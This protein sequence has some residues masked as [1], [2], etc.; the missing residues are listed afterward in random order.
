MILVWGWKYGG[1]KEDWDEWSLNSSKY[2]NDKVVRIDVRNTPSGKALL[3]QCLKQYLQQADVYLF[4]HRNHGYTDAAIQSIL[5]DLKAFI[6]KPGTKLRCF[7]FGEGNDYIYLLKQSRGL[8]GTKGT[9]TARIHLG[10]NGNGSSTLVSAIHDEEKKVLK[11][12]NF[13]AIWHYYTNTFKAKIFELKEDLFTS[14]LSFINVQNLDAL[15]LYQFMK[16][17]HNQLIFLRLLSFSGKMRKRS[18]LEG[19]LKEYE[20]R[21]KKSYLFDDCKANLRLIYGEKESQLYQE[22][23][24]QISNNLLVP[25]GNAD[26]PGLRDQ[27]EELLNAM[28]ESTYY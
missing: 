15:E 5:S 11:K 2:A 22:L 27:F 18:D 8:L 16:E 3:Y 9:F 10:N 28:P 12:E 24:S 23:V 14:L 21:R 17:G 26:L 1:L 13:N 7:L 25:K 6:A 4:L 19:N 20:V